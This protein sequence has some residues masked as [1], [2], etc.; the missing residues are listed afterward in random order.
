MGGGGGGRKHG[1]PLSMRE[2]SRASR[3]RLHNPGTSNFNPRTSTLS[4][5]FLSQTTTS[6]RSSVQ[7]LFSYTLE[8]LFVRKIQGF[9]TSRIFIEFP[10]ISLQRLP[11]VSRLL[12]LSRPLQ[13]NHTN[14]AQEKPATMAPI[15]PDHNAV[16]RTSRPAPSFPLCRIPARLC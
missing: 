13:L 12:H 11:R 7:V 9:S 16:E 3:M 10:S 2:W 1:P 6:E 5:T 8:C 15:E 4:A 14:H